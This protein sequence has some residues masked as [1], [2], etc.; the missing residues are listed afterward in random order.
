MVTRKVV[1]QKVAQTLKKMVDN[2]VWVGWYV[3]E[4]SVL[5]VWW[6]LCKWGFFQMMNVVQSV[7]SVPLKRSKVIF[8]FGATWI[9]NFHR[10]TCTHK[11]SCAS[12]DTSTMILRTNKIWESVTLTHRIDTDT[13]TNSSALDLLPLF[14]SCVLFC[15]CSNVCSHIH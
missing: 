7:S 12:Y 14:C 11:C 5:P 6:S 10:L 1:Y 2:F 4:C 9:S 15:R 8:F 13:A 3:L